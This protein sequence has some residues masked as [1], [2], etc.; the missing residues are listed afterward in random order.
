ML[1]ATNNKFATTIRRNDSNFNYKVDK[2]SHI[3]ISGSVFIKTYRN[4]E[5]LNNKQFPQLPRLKNFF[6]N[7]MRTETSLPALTLLY[8][9]KNS[10]AY[11]FQRNFRQ[12]QVIPGS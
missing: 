2:I 6:P 12:L 8:I 7:L 3:Y 10:R 4:K 1:L 5:L 11:G 9:M